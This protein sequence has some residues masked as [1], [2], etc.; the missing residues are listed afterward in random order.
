LRRGVFSGATQRRLR[1]QVNAWVRQPSARKLERRIGAQD[2][3]VVGVLVAEAD[4]ESAGADHVGE[5]M[6]DA[7]QVTTVRKNPGKPVGDPKPPLSH[8][9]QHGAAVRSKASAVKSGCARQLEMKNGR[10]ISWVMASMV[11]ALARRV[12]TTKSYAISKHTT[13]PATTCA[14]RE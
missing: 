8:A 13:S 4:R 5:R 3:E 1:T 9:Q 10:V 11:R 14:C 6:R 12:G 7:H 2:V